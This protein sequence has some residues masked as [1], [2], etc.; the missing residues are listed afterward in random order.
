MYET[1]KNKEKYLFGETLGTGMKQAFYGVIVA[2]VASLYLSFKR[3]FILNIF[4]N[5][6]FF[7]FY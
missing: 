2:L 3:R 1:S 4:F 6:Q 5:I 7:L